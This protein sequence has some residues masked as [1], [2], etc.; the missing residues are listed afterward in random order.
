[1]LVCLNGGFV[2][3]FAI[4]VGGCGG[5]FL[6]FVVCAV[7]LLVCGFGVGVLVVLGVGSCGVGCAAWLLVVC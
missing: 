7:L 2:F 3:G 5:G 4:V 1:M 6:L